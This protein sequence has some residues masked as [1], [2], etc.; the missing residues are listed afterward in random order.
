M[1]EEKTLAKIA[2]DKI[3]TWFTEEYLK[4]NQALYAYG[5]VNESTYQLFVGVKTID[6]LPNRKATEKGWVVYGL[7]F[8][9]ALTGEITHEEFEKE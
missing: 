5:F 6:D 4:E 2:L 1:L 9:D 7:V 8:V 3:Y